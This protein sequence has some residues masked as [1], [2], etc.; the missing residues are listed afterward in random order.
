MFV[1]SNSAMDEH[2]VTKCFQV[3]CCWKQQHLDFDFKV[4]GTHRTDILTGQIPAD[5]DVQYVEKQ[6]TES[7]SVQPVRNPFTDNNEVT[8]TKKNSVDL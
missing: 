3:E 6:L 7:V 8:A 4:T 5:E 2:H 1:P